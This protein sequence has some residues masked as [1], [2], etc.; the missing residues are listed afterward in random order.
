MYD[1][2][3][4]GAG[5]A[6]CVLANRL[7]EDADISVLLLEAG[8]SDTKQEIHIPAA[9]S[10]LFKTPYDWGY[11]TEPEPAMAD[12]PMFW[13]RGRVL[14][15]SSSINAMIYIRG[16][17]NDYDGWRD[18]GNDG[19]GYD[20]VLP[21]FRK[22]ENQERGASEYHGVGG[23]LNVAD[24][25]HRNPI[26]A[27]FIEA[28]VEMGIPANPDFNGALQEG[29]GYYQV[30]QKKG[31]RWSAV[32]G[33]LKPALHRPNLTVRTATMVTRIEIEQGR[34]TGVS[35]VKDGKAESVRATR[36]VLICG[37]AIN[38]P[39]LLMLSGLGPADHLQSLGIAV[40]ADLPGVGRNLQDHLLAGVAMRST[41]PITMEKA[42]SPGSILNYLLFRKG[43]LSLNIA[44][45]G[46]F[47]KL[48]ADAPNPDIQ[49]LMAPAIFIDHG[50]HK[51]DGCGFSLGPALLR[52]RSRGSLMLRSAAP[53]DPPVI[54][55][56]Y[57]A[58][59]DDRQMM[60]DA[61]RVA[62]DIS[63]AKAFSPFQGG[64]YIGD[65][66]M[67]DAELTRFLGQ[68]AQT[69]YHP[70]GTCKMGGDAM[71]VVD[72]QLR[73]RGV[74]GLRVV[75]GS[76]MPAIVSGNTNAPIIMIAEKAAD[77]IKRA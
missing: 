58:D 65:P 61:M 11:F 13:P 23:P 29:A 49:F 71:A 39:Q 22:S 26:T 72:A 44:E 10:K 68:Y 5:S 14:G 69:N 18:L 52:P 25:T 3:I 37:G 62:I 77:M 70:V 9:F 50:F 64:M 54:H 47:I 34:A 7:S 4:V 27:A 73:V 40:V 48:R 75:D 6:G 38:S 76:I 28:C 57:L 35:Y 42:Q 36:E 55:A 8:G 19:W 2:I 43:P 53:I 15:G 32:N 74:E 1:Y 30:T 46:A 67:S 12:R 33:Y 24:L 16:H 59:D 51:P 56:N 66:T 17:R 45:A 60:V 20:D 21:Y 41:K 31:M 63:Q